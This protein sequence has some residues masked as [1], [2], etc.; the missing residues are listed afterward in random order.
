MR[1]NRKI[2]SGKFIA[3]M[4]IYAVVFLTIAGVGLGFFWKYIEAYEH[5]RPKNTVNAYIEQLTPEQMCAASDDL[6][7]AVDQRL[8]DRAQFDQVIKDALSGEL[9]YAK[10][11][12]E[13]T[14]VRQVYA[15][16]SGRTAIGTFAIEAGAQ[17]KYGFRRWQVTDSEFDFSYLMGEGVTV[18]VPSTYQVTVNG[19]LLDESYQVKTGIPY[20]ALEQFYGEYTLPTMVT[21]AAQNYLGD[22][23]M[24]VMDESGNPVTITSDMDMN[25]FLPQCTSEQ[26]QA[27]TEFTEKFVDLWVKFSGSTNASKGGNYHRLKK[28][29]SSDGAL[30]ER[31]YSAL[32]GLTFGQSNGAKILEMPV[33]RIVP[34]GD[35]L[36]MCDVT[37]VVRTMGRQGAVD[38]TSNMKL[39][40]ATE[41]G[42]L[43]LKAMERY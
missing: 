15:L 30:A 24:E 21:Y 17:D 36:Y 31:L 35:G 7:A 6:Y 27:V 16:R 14:E 1:R 12:S 2:F 13:S 20:S 41:D 43:R 4:V 8:Q 11:S 29:L 33:N 32:D 40:I 26:T 10:K 19:V 39:I 38:T 34:I 9:S 42:E 3:G 18:T 28:I 5:S 22:A 25:V 37:Y 23:V